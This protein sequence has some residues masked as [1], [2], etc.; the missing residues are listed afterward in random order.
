MGNTIPQRFQWHLYD[1]EV[2]NVNKF[3]FKKTTGNSGLA[4]IHKTVPN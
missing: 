2:R 1:Y 3:F 4:D